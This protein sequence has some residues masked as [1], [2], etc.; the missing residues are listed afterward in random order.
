LYLTNCF[1]LLYCTIFE[2]VFIKNSKTLWFS[3]IDRTSSDR[4]EGYGF[5]RSTPVV[6]HHSLVDD[7]VPG[8][9]ILKESVDV[10]P[11]EELI[12]FEPDVP[13][14]AYVF[15]LPEGRGIKFGQDDFFELQCLFEKEIQLVLIQAPDRKALGPGQLVYFCVVVGEI[16]PR[17][18]VIAVSPNN[19][20]LATGC[21]RVELLASLLFYF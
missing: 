12:F 10:D 15:V 13:K 7:L 6:A 21:D 3:C 4:N 16:L 2:I 19:G 14:Q 1:V 18:N 20:G 5:V 11:A 9:Y 17:R 8:S